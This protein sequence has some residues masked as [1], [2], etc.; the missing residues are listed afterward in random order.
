MK[1]A[2]YAQQL[3]AQLLLM[4][5][6]VSVEEIEADLAE[7]QCEL[8]TQIGFEIDRAGREILIVRQVPIWLV[9]ADIA[10]LIRDVL[11]DL[12]RFET[13]SRIQEHIQDI[14]ATLACYTAV[15]AQ[16]KLSL[17]EMN[18]LLR[19]MERT[20]RSNQ[21]NHGRPTWTQLDLKELDNLF[22]RGK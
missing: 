1:K 12:K 19:E 2:W 5:V 10:Q 18:A 3:E 15:R 16:R 17:R 4:P 20:E 14:L 7:Q 9:E 11:A 6:S 13:S 8:F 21:C 22:L